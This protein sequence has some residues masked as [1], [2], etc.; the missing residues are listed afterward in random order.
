MYERHFQSRSYGQTRRY[1]TSNKE[2]G[3]GW[4]VA[5]KYLIPPPVFPS[6]RGSILSRETIATRISHVIS[7][8]RLALSPKD[9]ILFPPVSRISS[10]EERSVLRDN[11]L[12]FSTIDKQYYWKSF[13][14]IAI[15]THMLFRQLLLKKNIK[16]TLQILKT[17]FE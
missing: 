5:V 6:D 16:K 7:T 4:K 13:N 10:I 8:F 2:S 1:R 14:K 12:R 17:E 9:Q 3:R 15:L 11:S